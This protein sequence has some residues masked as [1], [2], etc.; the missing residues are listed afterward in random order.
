MYLTRFRPLSLPL[1][2]YEGMLLVARP[3]GLDQSLR[4]IGTDG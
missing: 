2:S 4:R 1:P 3:I